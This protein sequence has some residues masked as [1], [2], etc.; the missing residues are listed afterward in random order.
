MQRGRDKFQKYKKVIMTLATFLSVL[1]ISFRK[2]LFVFFRG[3]TGTKGLVLR[4]VLIKSI[5]DTCGD[6]VSIHPDVVIL[7]PE[8]L[9]IGSNVSIH[10]WG[11]IDSDGYIDIGDNV[12]IAHSTTI[13]SSTHVFKDNNIPIKD[14]GLMKLKTIINSNTWI[15]CKS[16]IIAGVTLSEGTIIG[17][18]SMVNRDTDPYT[19]VAGIPA[20]VLKNRLEELYDY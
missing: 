17:A 7:H 12:S 18:N 1:P 11:Y 9:K 3:V 6:N 13:L 19:T 10:T 8:K 20:K 4:Y 16:T 15:G 14:Q 5:A 2:N